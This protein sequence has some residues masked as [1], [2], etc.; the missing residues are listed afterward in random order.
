[1][2]CNNKSITYNQN[3]KRMYIEHCRYSTYFELEDKIKATTCALP[4]WPLSSNMHYYFA[5][6]ERERE[7]E[8][9]K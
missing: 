8:G 2:A 1:M 4:Q 5:E 7:R 9:N 3:T 6:R